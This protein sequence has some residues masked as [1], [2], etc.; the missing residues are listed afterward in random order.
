MTH[1]R[2]LATTYKDHVSEAAPHMLPAAKPSAIAGTICQVGMAQGCN[3]SRT[4]LSRVAIIFRDTSK[5]QCPS[6][7]TSNAIIM[8][9]CAS[10]VAFGH[11]TGRVRKL[12]TLRKLLSP[13]LVYVSVL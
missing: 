8:P 12:R 11:K 1:M 13:F 9:L 4:R 5:L 7:T 2:H 10:H 6:S 3:A